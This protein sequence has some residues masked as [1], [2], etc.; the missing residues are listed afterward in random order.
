MWTVLLGT[1][2]S[3][4]SPWWLPR[5]SRLVKTLRIHCCSDQSPPRIPPIRQRRLENDYEPFE[6]SPVDM[7]P[8][9]QYRYLSKSIE[10]LP[11][12]TDEFHWQ[13]SLIN[14]TWRVGK[15]TRHPFFLLIGFILLLLRHFGL[16]AE[17]LL[18]L[19]PR[20]LKRRNFRLDTRNRTERTPTLP[21][22]ILTEVSITSDSERRTDLTLKISDEFRF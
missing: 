11:L 15:K 13:C 16:G 12:T 14:S 7:I 6:R 10:L 20:I 8:S 3:L 18:L 17:L 19:R 4:L 2:M 1:K 5:G 21:L 22:R 9:R